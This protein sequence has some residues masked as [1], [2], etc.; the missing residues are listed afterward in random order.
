MIALFASIFNEFPDNI[1]NKIKENPLDCNL[2]KIIL[3]T[4]DYKKELSAWINYI[5][6]DVF[7]SNSWRVIST[8]PG[9]NIEFD[10]YNVRLFKMVNIVRNNEEII[11]IFKTDPE[12]YRLIERYNTQY[13]I[14]EDD[15]YE[16][17]NFTYIPYKE[18][19]IIEYNNEK[20]AM[21]KD[22]IAYGLFY[23]CKNGNNIKEVDEYLYKNVRT[24]LHLIELIL[25]N[26]SEYY[27]KINYM[28]KY[29]PLEI[30][31]SKS[32]E[33]VVDDGDELILV[34]QAALDLSR[35]INFIKKNNEL[36]NNL[37][38]YPSI[39]KLFEP[40]DIMQN[41]KKTVFD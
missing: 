38:H 35:I 11:I 19:T 9:D 1:Y 25:G 36:F 8:D 15:K 34:D 12:I 40:L 28:I 4:P 16:I 6:Y 41:T 17:E 32:F 23:I 37:N 7:I 3:N 20:Y 33:I 31:L 24:D 22:R 13:N 18:H 5:P 29:I 10:E 27:D 30:I 14:S 26:N 21:Y 39:K 2:I